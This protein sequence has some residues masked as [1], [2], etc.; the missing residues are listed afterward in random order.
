M[1][2]GALVQALGF[3]LV[4]SGRSGTSKGHEVLVA[5]FVVRDVDGTGHGTGPGPA[6]ARRRT[7]RATRCRIGIAAVMS[8]SH[9]TSVHL[10][11][12]KSTRAAHERRTA[13][14]NSASSRDFAA[15]RKP[16]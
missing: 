5:P 12:A 14:I 3:D 9:L 4:A 7:L 11:T 1:M 6:R 10:G 16:A 8:V 15:I 2:L 13:S